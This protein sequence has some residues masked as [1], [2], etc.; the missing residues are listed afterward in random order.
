MKHDAALVAVDAWLGVS[1]DSQ[2]IEHF[3]HGLR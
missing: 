1:E 3:M 2:S